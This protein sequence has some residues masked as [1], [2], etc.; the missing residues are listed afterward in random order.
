MTAELAQLTAPDLR[1]MIVARDVSPV[2]VL[3]SCIRQIETF[4]PFINAVT[5]T[6]FD[7]ALDEARAAERAILEGKSVGILHGLPMGVK[8]LEETAGLLTTY[9]SSLYRGNIP[10]RD[11]VLVGRLR[12]AGAVLVGKTNVPEFG[13]G[14]NTRNPVWGATGNPFDPNLNAGGSSGGSAAALACDML[15]ICTGSDT[16]GSLR[17]PAAKCGVVGMRPSPGLVP[18]DRRQLGWSPLSVVGPMGRTVAETALQLAATVGLSDAEPLSYDADAQA[19]LDLQP[20]DLSTLRV[21]FTEDFGVCE[22][23]TAVR[24]T[25]RDKISRISGL[26]ASCEP[27]DFATHPLGD[28]HRCFDIVRSQAFV[29]AMHDAYERD[30]DSIGPNAR[31][32]YELG[33]AFTMADAAWAHSKQTRIFRAFQKLYSRYDVILTPTTPVSPFAWTH[34]Y[35]ESING[36]TLPNYYRWLDLTYVV[37]L[38]TNPSL[39]LPCGRDQRNLPFGLQVVAPFRRDLR[40][41]EIASAL[42]SAFSRDPQLRRPHPD[43]A[44]LTASIPPLR[45]IVTHPPLL[46][47]TDGSA[48]ISVV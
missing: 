31:A 21:G 8:D 48:T 17:I 23:D 14:A 47:S 10:A 6:C 24:A 2:E 32:N 18:S 11:N 3:Q 25:F 28:V 12:A 22:V 39:S 41:L 13:A 15:P 1:A 37:T 44:N 36:K 42:E 27:I 38:A 7:R 40:L 29:A 34:L 46:E 4:N 16:G 19:F 5:A 30:P 26:F 35:A 9:G 33:A 43:L 20:V 45:S